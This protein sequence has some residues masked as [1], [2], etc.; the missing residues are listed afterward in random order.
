MSPAPSSGLPAGRPRASARFAIGSIRCSSQLTGLGRQSPGK[1]LH[2]T[3]RRPADARR[4]NHPRIAH[5]PRGTEP[6]RFYVRDCGN[7]FITL[8]NFAAYLCGRA[9]EEISV[10]FRVISDEV[11]A[12]LDFLQ[13]PRAFPRKSPDYK[14]G[15]AGLVPIQDFKQLRCDSRIR[16]VVESYGELSAEFVRDTAGPKSCE[17][18]FTAPY[19]I[20]AVAAAS[21]TGAPMSQGF[22]GTLSHAGTCQSSANRPSLSFRAKR[23]GLF[24]LVRSCERAAP[25]S[26][27]IPVRLIAEPGCARHQLH[28]CSVT[29]PWFHATQHRPRLACEWPANRCL[30][31]GT[32]Y[33]DD[34][35]PGPKRAPHLSCGNSGGESHPAAFLVRTPRC[36][37]PACRSFPVEIRRRSHPGHY[38]TPQAG[39][40]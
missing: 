4:G 15:S 24:F 13:Q 17:R 7:G 38:S 5:P 3:V 12:I 29:H 26:R 33:T 22:T 1:L 18:G 32:S 2:K 9:P 21:V 11:P 14:K 35:A 28:T 39:Q 6:S 8:L 20:A 27:G 19:E 37:P 40:V 23:R 16:T 36:A 31:A 30:T 25:R 10:S 34:Y